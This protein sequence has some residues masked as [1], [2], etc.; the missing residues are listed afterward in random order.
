MLN[1]AL[2]VLP[3][4]AAKRSNSSSSSSSRWPCE[5][6]RKILLW[7]LLPWLQPQLLLQQRVL[8]R[9]CGLCNG[10]LMLQ[11]RLVTLHCCLSWHSSKQAQLLTGTHGSSSS[12]IAGQAVDHVTDRVVLRATAGEHGRIRHFK[13][14]FV[15]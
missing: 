2:L 10:G 4:A 7:L 1:M 11:P 8:P 12:S 3:A 13:L 9:V 15:N 6:V 14:F 5:A